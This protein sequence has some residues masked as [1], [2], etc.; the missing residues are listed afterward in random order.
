M[1]I[2]HS[3]LLPHGPPAGQSDPSGKR[4]SCKQHC[5][6]SRYWKT[7]TKNSLCMNM[8]FAHLP[9]VSM[10]GTKVQLMMRHVL[11]SK[12]QLW[13]ALLVLYFFF[14]LLWCVSSIVA[15]LETKQRRF[16]EIRAKRVDSFT[17]RLAIFAALQMHCLHVEGDWAWIQCWNWRL[18]T[19]IHRS[20]PRVHTFPVLHVL[21]ALPLNIASRCNQYFENVFLC[22]WQQRCHTHLDV[23]LL[24]YKITPHQQFRCCCHRILLLSLSLSRSNPYIYPSGQQTGELFI[25]SQLF[26]IP[27]L[28]PQNLPSLVNINA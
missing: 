11:L 20:A 3:S 1:F 9:P 21:P 16:F 22:S 15:V 13:L 23:F 25:Q 6:L 4:Q 7:T 10:K 26:K 19:N 2:T 27:H 24:L 18:N 12:A 28:L 8:S 5:E 14:F 17:L